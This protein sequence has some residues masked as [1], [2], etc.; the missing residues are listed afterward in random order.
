[1]APIGA[2]KFERR[3]I[4]DVEGAIKKFMPYVREDEGTLE[5]VVYQGDKDPSMIVFL[6]RYRDEKA[7]GKHGGEPLQ[8]MLKVLSDAVDG[9][10]I[11][12][13]FKE[14]ASK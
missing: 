4:E 8:E 3:R 13:T 9:E 12:G 11:T 5:Y 1:M 2:A 10:A 14:L 7:W 6:E